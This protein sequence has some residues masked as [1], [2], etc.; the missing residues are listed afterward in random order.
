MYPDGKLQRGKLRGSIGQLT[1]VRED[2]SRQ[3]QALQGQQ[4][5]M[6][7]ELFAQRCKNDRGW[8]HSR[9]I[10]QWNLIDTVE[11]VYGWR[12]PSWAPKQLCI[13][14]WIFGTGSNIDTAERSN[15]LR[16]TEHSKALPGVKDSELRSTRQELERNLVMEELS[17]EELRKVVTRGAP[18]SSFL[19]A[20]ETGKFDFC[21]DLLITNSSN[22]VIVKKEPDGLAKSEEFASVVASDQCV[23]RTVVNAKVRVLSKSV[24]KEIGGIRARL[25]ESLLLLLAVGSDVDA[26]E[27]EEEKHIVVHRNAVGLAFLVC[28]MIVAR[29][30]PQDDVI[31]WQELMES[32]LSVIGVGLDQWQPSV[33]VAGD[34]PQ[35]SALSIL[36]GGAQPKPGL[37]AIMDGEKPEEN[38]ALGERGAN[39]ARDGDDA[40]D[41]EVVQAKKRSKVD[42][43]DSANVVATKTRSALGKA[44]MLRV[45]HEYFNKY[46]SPFG[47]TRAVHDC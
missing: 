26:I 29:N 27:F 23:D 38:V 13:P 18:Q 25:I 10:E 24:E 45:H 12:G 20:S 2:A 40:A 8:E 4:L 9:I 32:D 37:K 41:D 15:G 28:N 31:E 39:R 19:S 44:V 35:A 43:G 22:I 17:V 30:P 36:D 7:Y 6:D 16:M 47:V 14:T 46:S 21:E 34:A 3:V 5:G 11:N 33:T 1:L 42:G